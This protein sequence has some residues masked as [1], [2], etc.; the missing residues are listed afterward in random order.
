VADFA[1]VAVVDIRVAAG[2]SRRWP[3]DFV[4]SFA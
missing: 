2:V 1:R 4:I 3:G